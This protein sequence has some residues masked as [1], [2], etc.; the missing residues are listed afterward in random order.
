VVVQ[1]REGSAGREAA[2]ACS[3]GLLLAPTAAQGE[4]PFGVKQRRERQD[5]IRLMAIL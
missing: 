3:G 4:L 5:K 2:P 1:Q